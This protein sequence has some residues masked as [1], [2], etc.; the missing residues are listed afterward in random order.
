MEFSSNDC[1]DITSN[2][3]NVSQTNTYSSDGIVEFQSV[4]FNNNE[5]NGDNTI[6]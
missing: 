6:L 1:T 3:G 4:I 5:I 2:S